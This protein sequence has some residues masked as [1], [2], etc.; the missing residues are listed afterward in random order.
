MGS[1]NFLNS[2]RLNVRIHSVLENLT[3]EDH[4]HLVSEIFW[5]R[6]RFIGIKSAELFGFRKLFGFIRFQK[7]VW[8]RIGFIP[9]DFGVDFW[10]K[11][12]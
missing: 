8:M 12:D 3:E 11:E 9:I 5:M 10:I 4:M 2:F 1:T 7:F 6:I